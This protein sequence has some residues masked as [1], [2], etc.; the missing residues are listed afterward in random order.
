MMKKHKNLKGTQQ[1]KGSD[2]E[3]ADHIQM[4]KINNALG[5]AQKE[6]EAYVGTKGQ[7]NT[8]DA[9]EWKEELNPDDFE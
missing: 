6:T 1:Y 7:T 4:E 5:A 9:T 3:V 8:L 2:L